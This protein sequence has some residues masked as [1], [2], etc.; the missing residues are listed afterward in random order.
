MTSRSFEAQQDV[1]DFVTRQF[2]HEFESGADLQS[3]AARLRQALAPDFHAAVAETESL[4]AGTGPSPRPQLA[5]L[6]A[7]ARELQA[8]PE[9]VFAA[10]ERS[11]RLLQPR[12]AETLSGALSFGVYIGALVVLLGLVVCVYTI[13]VLPKFESVFSEFDAPLP[14]FTR[15]LLGSTWI[16]V[17]LLLVVLACVAAYFERLKRLKQRLARLEAVSPVLRWVPGL[18]S[19]A[20]RYDGTLWLRYQAIFIEA[21]ADADAARL[22]ASRIVGTTTG[23]DDRQALFDA[24]ARLGRAREELDEQLENDR[25]ASLEELEQ[26]RNIVVT[27]VR[28]V[29]YLVVGAF[30]LAMYLPIFKLGAT[31]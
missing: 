23:V 18:R 13:F 22:A 10:Y 21:G 17:P 2:M 31:I 30:V 15:S 6:I 1:R 3:A 9:R 28:A 4:V 25:Q 8:S 24:A 7:T 27:L 14:A 12:F 29:V 5:A 11:R 20:A 16:L 19:W 26:R